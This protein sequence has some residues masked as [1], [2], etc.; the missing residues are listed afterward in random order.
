MIMHRLNTATASS[1]WHFTL[2]DYIDITNSSSSGIGTFSGKVYWCTSLITSDWH[3]SNLI[4]TAAGSIVH[5]SD[6]TGNTPFGGKSP[7]YTYAYDNDN[8]NNEVTTRGSLIK[9]LSGC[10]I[11]LLDTEKQVPVLSVTE[12]TP[13]AKPLY[14]IPS[15]R[16]KFKELF[17][18]LTYWSSW[19]PS[20]V[21]NKFTLVE[22][23]FRQP[24]TKAGALD[25]KENYSKPILVSRIAVYGLP[26]DLDNQHLLET[27]N[28]IQKPTF[29]RDQSEW[30]ALTCV[31]EST[32]IMNIKVS[33]TGPVVESID[34]TKLL[35]SEIRILDPSLI[36]RENCLYLGVLQP[37]REELGISCNHSV[38]LSNRKVGKGS[39]EEVIL[40][41]DSKADLD[42]WFVALRALGIAELLSLRGSDKSNQLRLS[43]KFKL[44]ILEAN[45]SALDLRLVDGEVF[46]CSEICM[47]GHV[48]AKTPSVTDTKTP[49]W[50]EEYEFN[51]SVNINSLTINLIEWINDGT[52]VRK[53]LLGSIKFSQK[54]LSH[55]KYRNETRI[56]VYSATNE[57]F[58]IGTICVRITSD[59]EFVLPSANYSKF[60]RILATLNFNKLA[61][62]LYDS[63]SGSTI[64]DV[65]LKTISVTCLDMFQSLGLEEKWFQ[66]LIDREVK[67]LDGSIT[68]NTTKN[69]TTTHIYNTIFRGNSMLTKSTEKYFFRVGHEYLDRSIGVILRQ[70]I[71]SGESCELDPSRITNLGEHVQEEEKNAI[72]KLHHERLIKWVNALWEVIY[73]T[74]NDLPM[75]IRTQMKV[76]RREL[77][78]ICIDENFQTTLHCVSGFLFLRFFCPVILNPKLFNF[79]E[80]HLE[81]NTRRTLTLLSK[82]LL[83]LSTLTKFGSKEPWMSEINSFIDDNREKLLDYIDKVT[84]KK[85]D[86]TP[87][88][89]ELGGSMVKQKLEINSELL[90]DLPSNPYLIDRHLKE[91]EFIRMLTG[92]SSTGNS[93]TSEKAHR[94]EINRICL[95]RPIG[96][97]SGEDENKVDIGELEFERITEDNTETFGRDFMDFLATDSDSEERNDKHSEI[98]N[99]NDDDVSNVALFQEMNLIYIKIERLLTLLS[100]FEHPTSAASLDVGFV[101]RL[102]NSLCFTPDKKIITD[103]YGTLTMGD[104]EIMK[105]FI[106]KGDS[107]KCNPK[108]FS[109]V[110]PSF[111]GKSSIFSYPLQRATSVES[112]NVS[113]F[114]FESDGT[115]ST[116]KGLASRLSR[117]MTKVGTFK[118]GGDSA[119]GSGSGSET[120]DSASTNSPGFGKFS[121]WL[122]KK[123]SA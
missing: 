61:A 19:R 85:L 105:L 111:D 11:R 96:E 52:N 68:K 37:L 33:E 12:G 99:P 91:T 89:L 31:L 14:L 92:I 1:N 10:S 20:G 66:A 69:L 54:Q 26:L 44:A 32:G 7:R 64:P 121:R 81:G 28:G 120:S 46:L 43:N 5:T 23:N 114:P 2:Q 73:T 79:T 95:G 102:A 75:E 47:W 53:K 122:R 13:D 3:S 80:N 48:W 101:E 94:S 117:V 18:A 119:K 115:S 86:F 93:M 21:F 38:F 42:K 72:I 35:R 39:G 63:N 49:F 116:N 58:Q 67:D 87:R 55:P 108:L 51:E 103:H 6:N 88:V 57:H 25:N 27:A 78:K 109:V 123:S 34:I 113:L 40:R 29:L 15:N 41:F 62:S 107:V 84:E 110:P 36:P 74:S 90:E 8:N 118:G 77:E 70:I 4:V 106:D 104:S 24:G 83:N 82:V 60:E 30:Y 9:H 112:E 76:F 50:R 17:C 65:E 45:L 98:S 22:S 100:D 16:E 56:P 97:K 71:K 59:M